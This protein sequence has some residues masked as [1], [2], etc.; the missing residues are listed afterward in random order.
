M[1]KSKQLIYVTRYALTEGVF[2]VMADVSPEY[3]GM[4]SYRIDG[5]YLQHAHGKDWHVMEETAIARAE[6]M[7]AK[8]IES[9]RKKLAE[10]ERKTFSVEH[11]S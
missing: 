9:M 6:E 4:A 5:G 2:S 3:P 1:S 10:L 7:R 8:K 11:K